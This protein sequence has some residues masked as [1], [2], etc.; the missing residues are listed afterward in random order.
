MAVEVRVLPSPKLEIALSALV[1]KIEAG[2]LKVGFLAGVNYPA[3]YGKNGK[4]KPALPVAT[5]AFWN[6]FGT[7]RAPPRPFFRSTITAQ[8]ATWGQN[9]GK[10]LIYYKYD[11][12]R[13]LMAV[14]ERAKDDIVTSIMRWTAPPNAPYT[15]ARKGFQKPLTHT[16]YMARTVDYQITP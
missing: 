6:E 10:A 2:T 1:N 5:V 7:K 13:A 15:V 12:H 8:S 9:L 3:T 14:G 16:G 4:V 11:G